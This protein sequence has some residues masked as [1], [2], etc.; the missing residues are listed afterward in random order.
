MSKKVIMP[1]WRIGPAEI[2]LYIKEKL[3]SPY[4][5][6][7][8]NM[9]KGIDPL[10]QC[11]YGGDNDCTLTSIT[12][13]LAFMT[14]QDVNKIYNDVERVAKKYFYNPSTTGTI[15]IFISSIMNTLAKMYNLPVK[16]L[17]KYFKDV[18]FNY[19]GIMNKINKNVPVIINITNDGR[20]CYRN[21]SIL[22]VG[23]REYIGTDSTARMLVVY[24]N[25]YDQVSYVDY[26]LLKLC[27]I[28][29]YKEL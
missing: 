1:G 9:V 11:N 24:D 17:T 4:E 28:N 19:K 13:V 3:N 29:Y 25:W 26:D 6:L 10:L 27:S 8:E 20:N 22:I 15:P 5:I 18:Q 16:S 14:H 23:Y 2:D 7:Y 21:H 12:T